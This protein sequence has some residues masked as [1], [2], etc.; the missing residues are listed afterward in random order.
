MPT[1]TY[2]CKVCS[3]TARKLLKPQDAAT[4]VQYCPHDNN[5]LER[6]YGDISTIA[7]ETI[8]SPLWPKKVEQYANAPELVEEHERNADDIKT[9]NDL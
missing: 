8:E 4:V 1:Y 6:Q 9:K 2:T 7:K 5:P 3:F